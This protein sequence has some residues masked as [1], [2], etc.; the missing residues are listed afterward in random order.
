MRSPTRTGAAFV[1]IVHLDL[2]VTVTARACLRNA[3][4]LG[5]V[6]CANERKQAVLMW[7]AK[8]SVSIGFQ[9]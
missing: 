1:V 9:R 3:R 7:A 8:M 2:Q 6:E 5:S 4:A